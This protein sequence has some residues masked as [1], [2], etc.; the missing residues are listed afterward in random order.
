MNITLSING[1]Y[2]PQDLL[3]TI[4]M[5]SGLRSIIIMR[6]LSMNYN[7]IMTINLQRIIKLFTG[8]DTDIIN[9][10]LLMR[11]CKIHIIKSNVFAGYD[12]S[13]I[14]T[15]EA[16]FLTFS[17]QVYAFGDNGHSQLGLG[18]KQ[19]YYDHKGL[20]I[21]G[22]IQCKPEIISGLFD[23]NKISIGKCHVLFLDDKNKVY[24]CGSNFHHQLGSPNNLSS[25]NIPTIINGLNDIIDISIS[26]GTSLVLRDDGFILLFGANRNE[27]LFNIF[28]EKIS[29][30]TIIP[31]ISNIKQISSDR[32]ILCLSKDNKLSGFTC[33][34]SNHIK[35]LDKIK[36]NLTNDIVC[37]SNGDFFD[38]I[39]TSNYRVNGFFVTTEHEAYSLP[40]IEMPWIIQVASGEC[41]YILLT[42]AGQIVV[43]G[44]NEYGQLGLGH[45][46][47]IKG[48]EII[49]YFDNIIKIAVGENHSLFL[50]EDETIYACGRNDK[51]QLGL[52]HFNSVNI[53]MLVMKLKEF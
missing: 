18:L 17:N 53:P 11:L 46:D 40:K 49:P 28:N 10:E 38:F 52:G 14:T 13:F 7:T 29:T 1:E 6:R 30:P 33:K 5:Y 39:L 36:E 41:H 21:N 9:V 37:I 50:T 23:I 4:F 27:Q 43:T 2:I 45:N 8:F 12:S 15:D 22:E 32:D 34:S 25:K 3:P 51:G 26:G 42:L 48:P 20:R 16:T 31:N 19:S 47:S 44:Y 35:S 24:S